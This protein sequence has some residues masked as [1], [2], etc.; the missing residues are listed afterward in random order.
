MVHEASSPTAQSPKQRPRDAAEW[1]E[2][3]EKTG[4]THS[5]ELIVI[6]QPALKRLLAR[7]LVT[8]SFSL[9]SFERSLLTFRVGQ[10]KVANDG[11]DDVRIPTTNAPTAVVT[12]LSAS[13]PVPGAIGS[14]ALSAAAINNTWFNRGIFSG[15][16]N[17]AGTCE[18]DPLINS[19]HDTRKW[20]DRIRKCHTSHQPKAGDFSTLAAAEHV[21]CNLRPCPACAPTCE[22]AINRSVV[23][24]GG[25]LYARTSPFTASHTMELPS[26]WLPIN[27]SV[28]MNATKV[29]LSC[30]PD[31]KSQN[32]GPISW[33]FF[34]TPANGLAERKIDVARRLYKKAAY[35]RRPPNIYVLILESVSR[36]S[37]HRSVPKFVQYLRGVHDSGKVRVAEFM[38][39]SSVAWGTGANT[40]ALLRGCADLPGPRHEVERYNVKCTKD[41]SPWSAHFGAA[42]YLTLFDDYHNETET[43]YP[44]SPNCPRCSRAPYAFGAIV[45]QAPEDCCDNCVHYRRNVDVQVNGAVNQMKYYRAHAPDLPHYWA[46]KVNDNHGEAKDALHGTD[47]GFRALVDNMDQDNSVVIIVGD[48]GQYA[49]PRANSPHGQ[50]EASNPVMVMVYPQGMLP[51]ASEAH[52][53]SAQQYLVTHW[54]LHWTVRNLLGHFSPTSPDAVSQRLDEYC[55]AMEGTRNACGYAVGPSQGTV[56]SPDRVSLKAPPNVV[57]L[58]RQR[59]PDN[60]TCADAHA[61]GNFCFCSSMSTP[62]SNLTTPE[63]REVVK[64]A[65]TTINKWTGMGNFGCQELVANEFQIT[66]ALKLKNGQ[67]TVLIESD[68]ADARP[69]YLLKLNQKKVF[70]EVKNPRGQTTPDIMRKDRYGNECCLIVPYSAVKTVPIKFNQT[71]VTAAEYK[72]YGA[73]NP[74]DTQLEWC[75]CKCNLLHGAEKQP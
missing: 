5:D 9:S 12:A 35:T 34:G 26:A 2:Y 59:V 13:S 50:L 33:Y 11:A 67:Y 42:G 73:A 21:N 63:W 27:A 70:A 66:K 15:L 71:M 52:L 36:A 49:G 68:S 20:E 1:R 44:S 37:F 29:Y 32:P 28:S 17:P 22:M 14:A 43:G 55:A 47:A 38:R 48:H 61:L 16:D 46:V 72:A 64:Q 24:P 8:G 30:Q 45:Y 58:T 25:N 18:V 57:D 65:I 39:S 7:Q 10:E 69:E 54:D 75:R 41:H 62:V 51:Q 74:K 40:A 53:R 23:C 19:E 31:P 6:S 4:V 60:R 3:M 56:M